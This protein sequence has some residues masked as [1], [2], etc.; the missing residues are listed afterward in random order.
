VQQA[1]DVAVV[2]VAEE[3][4]WGTVSF[5]DLLSLARIDNRW[6]IVTKLFTHT[7]GEPPNLG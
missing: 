4:Y 2:T 3:G 6:R 7:G 5:V 1:G